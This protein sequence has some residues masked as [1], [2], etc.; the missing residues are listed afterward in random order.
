MSDLVR[1]ST[2]GQFVNWI[3]NGRLLP[4][5]DQKPDY[6]VPERYLLAHEDLSSSI[7]PSSR[8]EECGGQPV[9]KSS[10]RDIEDGALDTHERPPLL[11]VV[12]WDGD[13]DPDN[14][15]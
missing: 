10:S 14:P 11:Y 4:Y 1:E 9:E 6:Q 15:K 8:P 5:R 12:D 13:D 2:F 3:T 7:E